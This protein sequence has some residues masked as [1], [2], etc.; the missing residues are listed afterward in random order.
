MRS[1]LASSKLVGNKKDFS[2][3]PNML[4]KTVYLNFRDNRIVYAG[5]FLLFI[6]VILLASYAARSVVTNDQW[7]FIDVIRDYYQHGLSL[8]DIW[9][10]HGAHRTPGYKILFL[11]DAIYFHLNLKLEIYAGILALLAMAVMIYTRYRDSM[12]DNLSPLKMQLSF[13]V[14]ATVIFSFNQ[15]ALYFYSLS[16]LDGFLG[17]MLFVWLWCYMDKGIRGSL[18][19]DFILKFCVAFLLVLLIFG[20]GMGVAVI[21]ACL[22]VMLLSG[23]YSHAWSGRKY[24]VL[25]IAT[26]LTGILSQVIYWAVPP[27]L[28]QTA[29]LADVMAI[30]TNIWGAVQYALTTLGS[31]ILSWFWSRLGIRID[32]AMSVTGFIV[33]LGYLAAVW[34][35]FRTRMWQKT[36]LPLILMLYSVLFLGLL[37]VGR[38]GNGDINS[39]GAPRYAAD[40]QLGLVG[41]LWIFYYARYSN[42]TTTKLWLKSVVVCATVVV[43]CMQASSAV[44]QKRLAP[45]KRQYNLNFVEYLKTSQPNDIISKGPVLFCPDPAL[46][47][48]G[49]ETLRRYGLSPFYPVP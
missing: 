41:I 42:R 6:A 36:W 23:I 46:C 29:H 30:F 31:S 4:I 9:E 37:L 20:E 14:I 26:A 43:L 22:I 35:F 7:H 16:A 13:L 11:L 8:R 48:E 2:F 10:G 44:L 19:Y 39:A 1:R 33:F 45:F 15:W 18:T 5:L 3:I 49:V 38:Y 47:V 17:K 25:L 21:L 40:L 32:V 28:P 12:R 34:L 24:R 27:A